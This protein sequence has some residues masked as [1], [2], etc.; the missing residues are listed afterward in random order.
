M[1]TIAADRKH[2]GARIGI[3][4]VLHAWGLA[5]TYHPHIHMIVPGHGISLDGQRWGAS[6][7]GFLLPV[8]GLSKL[9]RRLFLSGMMALHAAGQLAF[10]GEMQGLAGHR[11]FLRHLAPL[12][13]KN[14][15][16][17]PNRLSRGRRRC[18][19]ISLAIRT[20]SPSPT[21]V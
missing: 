20:G 15:G 21:A 8:R 18:W 10:F 16:A 11:A 3:T 1:M 14:W 12:R 17:M 19:P 5:M 9:F 6:R 13:R 7:A 2:L 4:A